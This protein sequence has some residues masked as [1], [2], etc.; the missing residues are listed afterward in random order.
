MQRIRVVDPPQPVPSAAEGARTGSAA[1][2]DAELHAALRRLRPAEAEVLRLGAWEE[3]A[4]AQIATVL[5]IS[6]NA[7]SIRLHRAKK[8]LRAELEG[9]GAAP[10]RTGAPE[11][12]KARL[13]AG[14]VGDDGGSR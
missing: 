6:A 8:A 4:P 1:E 7:V 5:G 3:L 13:D 12:G 2:S 9:V 14:H 11:I 10:A